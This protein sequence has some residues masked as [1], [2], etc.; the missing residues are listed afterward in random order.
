M[1]K[2]G[3]VWRDRGSKRFQVIKLV[4]DQGN[5]WVH[6]REYAGEYL[7]PTACVREYSCYAG[8][9]VERFTEIV[10]T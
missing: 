3:S 1:I 10:N 7:S 8:S 2:E 4:E 5:T 9:F 6:Y